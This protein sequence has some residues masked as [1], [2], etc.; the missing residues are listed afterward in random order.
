MYYYSAGM[1]ESGCMLLLLLLAP[2]TPNRLPTCSAA[3]RRRH[4][5]TARCGPC[6]Q[7]TPTR[8]LDCHGGP[9]GGGGDDCGGS[10]DCGCGGVVVVAVTVVVVVIVVVVIVV[11]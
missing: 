8:D 9:G 6:H 11:V 3:L 7:M 4:Q 2:I 1:L 10:G 5:G